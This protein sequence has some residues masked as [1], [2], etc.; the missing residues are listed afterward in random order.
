M[1]E[2]KFESMGTELEIK[3]LEDVPKILQEKIKAR[4]V[5]IPTGKEI[6]EPLLNELEHFGVQF[7]EKYF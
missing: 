1:F 2:F 5:A 6:Y 4:G 7:E 3:I